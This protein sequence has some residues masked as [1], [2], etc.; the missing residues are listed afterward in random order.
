MIKN[1]KKTFEVFYLTKLSLPK[2]PIIICFTV[3][4]L[5]NQNENCIKIKHFGLKSRFPCLLIL[6]NMI[7]NI[8][9]TF[10][11]F[12]LA[13]LSCPDHGLSSVLL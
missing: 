8:K 4:R 1:I 9:K 7:K 3:S 5:T 13:K 2:S 12:Y 10:E 11:V 6:N